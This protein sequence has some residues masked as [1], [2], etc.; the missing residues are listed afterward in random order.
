MIA[1]GESGYSE[2][3]DKVGVHITDSG[4][5][6]FAASATSST[7]SGTEGEKLVLKSA[8]IRSD[9]IIMAGRDINVQVLENSSFRANSALTPGR[10]L[11][12]SANEAWREIKK[13]IAIAKPHINAEGSPKDFGLSPEDIQEFVLEKMYPLLKKIGD[14][15]GE[16]LGDGTDGDAN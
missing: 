12:A 8:L 7:S 13:A 2:L 11:L 14:N 15:T 3:Y 5:P 1:R 6:S 9:D 16:S 4:T 10:T